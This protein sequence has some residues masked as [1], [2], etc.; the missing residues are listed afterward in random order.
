MVNKPYRI[1][2]HHSASKDTT[3]VEEITAWHKARRF[4]TIG[5]HAVIHRL[6][7]TKDHPEGEVVVSPG[8]PETVIGAHTMSYNAN[9][10]G[11]CVCGNHSITEMS[12]DTYQVL[13]DHVRGWMS[14]YKIHASEVRG[15]REVGQTE[16]PGLL[17][18]LDKLRAD[19]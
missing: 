12:D 15:H 18:D 14:K 17:F 19:L 9:S 16:C 5:Y 1:Y 4:K 13:L 6:A 8:R 3:T 2:I 10:L 7:P 11:V